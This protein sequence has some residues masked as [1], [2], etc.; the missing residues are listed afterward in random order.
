MN[1]TP[2]HALV[3]K[4]GY[5]CVSEGVLINW[6]KTNVIFWHDESKR[7]ANHEVEMV[8]GKANYCDTVAA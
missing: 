2:S 6:S 4:S 3:I 5:Q 7:R 8:L 1:K